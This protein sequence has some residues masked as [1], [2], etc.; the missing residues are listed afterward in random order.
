MARSAG[1]R[2]SGRLCL[3]DVVAGQQSK[4]KDEDDKEYRHA[5]RSR[6]LH[7]EWWIAG[8]TSLSG[9]GG[10]Y[11]YG[12]KWKRTITRIALHNYPSGYSTSS[13]RWVNMAM[14]KRLC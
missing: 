7:L 13:A 12:G 6:T 3:V 1:S 4:S 10:Q 5:K 14:R 9:N 8:S 2:P 11:T